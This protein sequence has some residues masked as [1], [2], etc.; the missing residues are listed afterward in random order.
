M[1]NQ[2][3]KHETKRLDL[4]ALIL[5]IFLLGTSLVNAQT[6]IQKGIEIF[7]QKNYYGAKRFFT[8]YIEK[9]K[10]NAA[11]SKYPAACSRSRSF[12]AIRPR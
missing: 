5:I 11:S 6:D 2:N 3:T 12:I 8:E 1:K 7:N 9:N 10:Q 4:I